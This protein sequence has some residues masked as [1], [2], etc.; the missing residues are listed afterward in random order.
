[1]TAS[2][3]VARG[4]PLRA[5]VAIATLAVGVSL[6]Q[7]PRSGVVQH[8]A[9]AW[10][11]QVDRLDAAASFAAAGEKF[12]APITIEQ[13]A[14]AL[15][16]ARAPLGAAVQ[17][18]IVETAFDRAAAPDGG[19]E[20]DIAVI[21]FRTAFAQKTA[22]TESVTLALDADGAWRVIGYFIR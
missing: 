7:D 13:W 12:R 9:R 22:S 16:K 15:E 1:M 21:L 14:D 20:V 10:L 2:A 4:V 3:S 6:A 11:A 19:T 5:L 17:R 18:T 8:S